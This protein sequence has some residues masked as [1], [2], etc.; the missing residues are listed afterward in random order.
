MKVV[1]NGSYGGFSISKEAVLLGREIS[2]DPKWGGTLK[3]ECY[4]D[5]S[6]C[7]ND[8][9]AHGMDLSRTDPT[10]IEV[11]EKLGQKADGRFARLRICDV[12]S[13]KQ[14]RID[15]YDG[16]ECVMTVD[17]YTWEIAS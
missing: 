9:D 14:Y 7:D 8:W 3:G 17:D 10:L 2:G 5:G 6:L 1:S 15:E 16:K 4:E 11:I 13:G 12:Q